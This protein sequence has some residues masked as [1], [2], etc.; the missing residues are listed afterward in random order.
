VDDDEYPGEE[1]GA[2]GALGL[3]GLLEWTHARF[4][5]RTAAKPLRAVNARL[6][7]A[8]GS[9]LARALTSPYDEPFAD[10]AAHDGYAI[11]GEGPWTIVDL[12]QDVALS[13]HTAMR[14]RAKQIL[15]GHTDAVLRADRGV[16]TIEAANELVTARDPLTDLPEPFA[17]PDFGDGIVRTGEIRTSGTELV[18]AHTP[19]TAGILAL[20]AAAGMDAIEVVAPPVVGTLVLGSTLL[21]G[22]PPRE[23]RV[24]DALGWTIP[25]LI[26]SLGARANPPVRAPDTRD[27]LMQEINDANVDLLITTGSTSPGGDNILREALRDL[28]A[29]WL[30]DGILVTP[31]AQTLLARLPDGRLLLGLPGH[32]TAAL[33]GL[34]TLGAPVIAGLRGDLI[35]PQRCEPSAVPARARLSEPVPPAEYDEDTTLCPVRFLPESSSSTTNRTVRVPT[36]IPLAADGPADLRGW[37]TADAIAVVPPGAG[38]TEDEVDLLDN[39]GRPATR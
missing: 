26:G 12:A 38:D 34:L 2:A 39:R 6:D 15:P 16:I 9:V 29:H 4:V 18:H 20:A 5:A 3:D 36:A 22:G 35:E 28:G 25:A 14:V 17:R 19:V 11:C 32:P 8:H 33:A 10:A 24:R 27:L 31:G 23:G 30:V 21:T 7:E 37:A 13:Q 1:R